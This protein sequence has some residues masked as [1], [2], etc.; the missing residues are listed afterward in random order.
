[1]QRHLTPK[2]NHRWDNKVITDNGRDAREL[3]GRGGNDGRLPPQSV[4]NAKP[5]REDATRGLVP[6]EASGTSSSSVWLRRI[7]GAE[8]RLH[9]LRTRKKAYRFYDPAEGRA[10]MSRDVIFDESTFWQWNDMI[11]VD[12]NSNQFTVEYLITE[13][14]EGGAQHQEPLPTPAA[15][16]LEPVEF[17]TP[18]IADSTLDVDHDDGLV[19]RYRRMEDLLGRGEPPGL[20]AR[21]LEE[22]VV[23]QDVESGG[24]AARDTEP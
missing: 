15:A 19:V 22:E 23:E 13:S 20:A 14:E 11:E 12:H 9:R 5:R 6:Q 3:L 1:M 4:A 10:H 16:P 24:H 8:G 21:Q 2:S 18:R 17:T 7:Q